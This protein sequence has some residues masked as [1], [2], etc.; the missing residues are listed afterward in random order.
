LG[1]KG[2]QG[3][4]LVAEWRDALLKMPSRSTSIKNVQCSTY[5]FNVPANLDG[6]SMGKQMNL[7]CVSEIILCQKSIRSDILSVT[8]PKGAII[9]TNGAL[10]QCS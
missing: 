1:S 4:T 5:M 6:L 7:K 2:A 3:H 8:S 9:D 10:N